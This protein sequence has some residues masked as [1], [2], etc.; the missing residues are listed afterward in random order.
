MK[1]Q[2]NNFSVSA[3]V[4]QGQPLQFLYFLLKENWSLTKNPRFINLWRRRWKDYLEILLDVCIVKIKK[5]ITFLLLHNFE[6]NSKD[7]W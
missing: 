6:E 4:D 7:I 5:K 2:S 1:R 3:G